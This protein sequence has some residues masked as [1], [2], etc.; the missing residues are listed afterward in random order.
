MEASWLATITLPTFQGCSR[1]ARKRSARPDIPCED[2][3]GGGGE[4]ADASVSRPSSPRYSNR[5]H[6]RL[7][8]SPRPLV[9]GPSR[10]DG[11][12]SPPTAGRR[13]FL[14]R[15]HREVPL[16]QVVSAAVGLRSLDGSRLALR[17]PRRRQVAPQ[18]WPTLRAIVE[19]W[20][21]EP[22]ISLAAVHSQAREVAR[23]GRRSYRSDRVIGWGYMISRATLQKLVW[24]CDTG[25]LDD[26]RAKFPGDG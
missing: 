24:W 18:L 4:W 10:H 2:G 13:R 3:R 11:R 8:R 26:Y 1:P 5:D 6:Y 22:F 25:G 20:P 21:E 17:H 14:L 15:G 12:A 23:Q 19:A 7:R 16:D 9:V